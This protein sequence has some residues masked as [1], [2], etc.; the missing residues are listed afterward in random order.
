[1]RS[2]TFLVSWSCRSG[3]PS[4]RCVAPWGLFRLHVSMV[5]RPTFVSAVRGTG[6]DRSCGLSRTVFSVW[7]G[8]VPCVAP[9]L[10]AACWLWR[11][12][13][14]A[15]FRSATRMCPAAMSATT[16]LKCY[17]FYQGVDTL[18]NARI[19]WPCWGT[20]G[21]HVPMSARGS[22]RRFYADG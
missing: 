20:V 18:D 13:C 6:L 8:P 12:E 16:S 4:V 15:V 2:S 22:A 3:R 14:V 19:R 17:T 7:V 1:M 10:I 9:A 11:D 21:V 5:A